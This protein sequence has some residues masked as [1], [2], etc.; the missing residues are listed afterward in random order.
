MRSSIVNRTFLTLL[1]A[2]GLLSSLGC[3]GA[4]SQLLYVIKGHE[5]PAAFDELEGKRIAVVCISDAS[6]YGPDTL[7]YTISNALS[8][9]LAQ[10]LKEEETVIIPVTTVEEWIDTNGWNERDFLALGKGVEA[11][12]VVAVDVKSYTIHEGSTMFKGKSDVTATVYNIN[13][14]GQVDHHYGPQ[15]FEY[16]QHGRPAI[17][18]TERAFETLYLGRLV[19]VLAE[20]FIAHDH[21]DSFATDAIMNY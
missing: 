8:V 9:K 11:D 12:L 19:T 17:Q 6:A 2:F 14:E 1:I 7:T 15:L 5:M 21:L 16:P 13:K 20:Q 18:T 10:G 4:M 3:V